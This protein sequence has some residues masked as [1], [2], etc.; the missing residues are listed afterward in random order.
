[1]P[2]PRR[3]R[4]FSIS[5]ARFALFN[6]KRDIAPNETD[7]AYEARVRPQRELFDSAAGVDRVHVYEGDA[8]RRRKRGLEQ[9]KVDVMIAV[10]MLTHTFRRN[11]H[12]ATL[13]TGDNDFKPLVD[14]LVHEGMFITISRLSTNRPD[15]R[16]IDGLS[17][18][19]G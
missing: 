16:C 4:R 6:I 1:L 17:G 15:R 8:R 13:L 5:D 18:Q 2:K 9:K 11:M 7:Q 19:R 3:L 10:D 12:E 14:A